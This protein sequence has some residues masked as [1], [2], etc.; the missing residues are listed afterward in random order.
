MFPLRIS[1]ILLVF[2]DG[3]IGYD[4]SQEQYVAHGMINFYGRFRY[5]HQVHLLLTVME[6]L[7]EVVRSEGIEH[8]WLRNAEILLQRCQHVVE[9]FVDSGDFT[10][11]RKLIYNE[12][13]VLKMMFNFFLLHKE[14]IARDKVQDSFRTW[15]EWRDSHPDPDR[16]R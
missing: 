14:L 13:Y 6:N 1:D 2:E 4:Y 5:E 12:H 15:A 9:D 8:I 7:L 10:K 11:W 16:L 3:L